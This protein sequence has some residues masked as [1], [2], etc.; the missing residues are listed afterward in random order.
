MAQLKSRTKSNWEFV[1]RLESEHV[2]TF[3]IQSVFDFADLKKIKHG[4]TKYWLMETEH[5]E[6][7]SL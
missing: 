1:A 5:I 4:S 6:C 3:S 7:R 2:K